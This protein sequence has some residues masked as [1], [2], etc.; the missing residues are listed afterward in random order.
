MKVLHLSYHE[1]SGVT[2]ITSNQNPNALFKSKV[3]FLMLVKNKI[4][5]LDLKELFL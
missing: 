5:D 4:C 3:D 1:K 2:A